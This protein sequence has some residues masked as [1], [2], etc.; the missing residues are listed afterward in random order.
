M[1]G[2]WHISWQDINVRSIDLY[3]SFVVIHTMFISLLSFESMKYFHYCVTFCVLVL[4]EHLKNVKFCWLS[5]F[6]LDCY[7][8][9]TPFRTSI[10]FYIQ[11]VVLEGII[12]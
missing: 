1:V 11:N 2:V 6:F 9:L 10:E 5:I 7:I 12:I 8:K 4:I 3:Y